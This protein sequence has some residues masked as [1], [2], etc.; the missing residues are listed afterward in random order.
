GELALAQTLARELGE[1]LRL[2]VAR[3][4]AGSGDVTLEGV[5]L[6]R[7]HTHAACL[8]E[9]AVGF[10]LL[11]GKGRLARL[12]HVGS[13]ELP[14]DTLFGGTAAGQILEELQIVFGAVVRRLEQAP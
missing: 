8:G 7:A 11:V 10:G 13:A 3:P 5:D 14:G 6:G 2:R 9:V 4:L 1:A 12:A